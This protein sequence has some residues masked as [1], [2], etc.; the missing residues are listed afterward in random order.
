MA[1]RFPGRLAPTALV[2]GA[3]LLVGSAPAL[4]QDEAKPEIVWLE[5]GAGNPYWDAQ[6][7]AAQAAGDDLG[8]SFRA[9]SGNQDA[10]QQA[11]T[12]TQLVDQKPAAIMLNA[13][14]PE[15]TEPGVLYAKEQ[16]V[17]LINLYSIDPNAT[18]NVTFDD[19][20]EGEI[21]AKNALKLLEERNGTPTGTI[22]VLHGQLGQ[23][24]SDDRA[25]GFIDFME[26]QDG[27]EIVAVQETKWDGANATA[28]M[29]DWL[30]RFPELDMVYALSDTLARP[31]IGAA[32][33]DGRVCTPE[34][35]WTTNPGCVIFVAV[36]GF[37]V[38]DVPG[39][40]LYAT[41]LYSPQWS[42]YKFAEIAWDAAQGGQPAAETYLDALLVTPEN[43]E[44]VAEMQAEMAADP[45]SFPF[46]GSLAD[47][48]TA[49]GCA[50][51]S[52]D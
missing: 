11:A 12:L 25:A 13:I 6:H 10:A 27:V 38:E 1:S 4:A 31:A 50:I 35:D 48:A 34:A 24:A 20:K 40:T 8:F 43:G 9:V 41:Q 29:Q 39:G 47:I 52:A 51:V 46:E 21:A 44:C 30:V 28:A 37:F 3:T 33:N 49:R 45:A 7:Q 36:D 2:V 26:Q 19:R 14:N 32:E 22:A 42:G 18:A 5:Q 16:G 17:P 23:P 15:A